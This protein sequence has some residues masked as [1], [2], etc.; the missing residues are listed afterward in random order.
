ML[1][2]MCFLRNY[3]EFLKRLPKISFISGL[4]TDMGLFE[5]GIKDNDQILSVMMHAFYQ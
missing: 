5:H 4:H 2:K 3:L 1:H